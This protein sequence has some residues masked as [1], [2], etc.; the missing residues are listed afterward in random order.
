MSYETKTEV[1]SVF[2][3]IT[4][5]LFTMPIS[6]VC[7]DI[8]VPSLPNIQ[9]FFGVKKHLVQLTVSLFILGNASTQ[10]VFGILSDFYGRRKIIFFGSLFFALSAFLATQA[11]NVYFLLFMRFCAGIAVAAC[12]GSTRAITPDVF[13]GKSYNKVVI[14]MV[15]AWGLGPIIAP[16]IGGYLQHYFGWHAPFYFLTVYGLLIF[17]LAVLVLPETHLTRTPINLKGLASQLQ[18]TLKHPVFVGGSLIAG[19]TYGLIVIFNVM[20][21]FLIQ[22]ALGRSAVFYGYI[23]LILG[24]GFFSG[25]LLNRF[26]GQDSVSLRMKSAL[27]IILISSCFMFI[28]ALTQQLSI[29]AILLPVF[30]VFNCVGLIYP[31][32]MGKPMQL[33]PRFTGFAASFSGS[34]VFFISFL[35]SVVAGFFHVQ[36]LLPLALTYTVTGVLIVLTYIFLFNQKA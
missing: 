22:D 36:T 25:S 14:G 4:F 11:T 9:Q 8:Y 29:L 31:N 16:F 24:V 30:I 13:K 26:F 18:S 33:F 28:W 12:V 35:M 15:T 10:L 7:L 5:V 23:G 17:S 19:L 34:I 6:G 20:G 27:A 3:V 1:P 21:P 2:W 32:A